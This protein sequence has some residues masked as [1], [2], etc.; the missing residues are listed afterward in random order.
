MNLRNVVQCLGSHLEYK[1]SLELL[2]QACIYIYTHSLEVPQILQ[3]WNKIHDHLLLK[4]VHSLVCTSTSI[5][6]THQRFHRFCNVEVQKQDYRNK[7][8]QFL[9]KTTHQVSTDFVC[10]N[11]ETRYL[12][13]E[14]NSYTLDVPQILQCWRSMDFVILE[15]RNKT[16]HF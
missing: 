13:L 16:T 14:D 2:S 1:S 8:P 7:T 12:T 6:T 10:C 3:C 9:N 4:I 5:F 15:Q 11:I